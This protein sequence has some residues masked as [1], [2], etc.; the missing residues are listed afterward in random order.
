MYQKVAAALAPSVIQFPSD[1]KQEEAV[2][3]KVLD[4]IMQI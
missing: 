1:N 2:I 4:V 3:D